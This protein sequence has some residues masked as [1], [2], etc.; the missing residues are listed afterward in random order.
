MVVYCGS[1]TSWT[2]RCLTCCL[3]LDDIG[4]L[5]I[6]D[7]L[8]WE[9]NLDDFRLIV[10]DFFYLLGDDFWGDFGSINVDLDFSSD[11][12]SGWGW[13]VFVNWNFD[14]VNNDFWF[15]I[16]WY[17]N[18]SVYL[19]DSFFSWK[20]NSSLVNSFFISWD[21]NMDVNWSGSGLADGSLEITV[22][23]WVGDHWGWVS[24]G[25][26]WSSHSGHHG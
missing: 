23:H 24:H 19:L 10:I 11:D 2:I 7:N 20:L 5:F 22:N 3:D 18:F 26:S 8:G 1:Q 9:L 14:I 21:F 4:F 6:S 25:N 16:L 15:K 17:L 12:L 13:K